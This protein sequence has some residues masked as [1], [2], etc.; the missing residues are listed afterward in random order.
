ME[1]ARVKVDGEEVVYVTNPLNADSD[2]DNLIDA[3]EIAG[4]AISIGGAE[5]VVITNPN[6]PDTDGDGLTDYDEVTGVAYGNRT[7]K[8][9][10][11]SLDSDGDGIGDAEE[12]KGG[13]NPA[14]SDTDGDSI[15]DGD[16]LEL[17][18]DPAN[19]DTDGD[20]KTDGEETGGFERSLLGI[21][22]T[23]STD[24][25]N[26]DTDGD[27]WTD[28]EDWVP[29]DWFP[30]WLLR[31]APLVM[32]GLGFGLYRAIQ[33]SRQARYRRE[34]EPYRELALQMADVTRGYLSIGDFQRILNQWH[35]TQQISVAQ[36]NAYLHAYGFQPLRQRRSVFAADRLYFHPE[37]RRSFTFEGLPGHVELQEESWTDDRWSIYRWR[38]YL[39]I[40]RQTI[41]RAL[42]RLASMLP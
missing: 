35:E 39:D 8:I 30:T 18:T 40:I 42:R 41:E 1:G 16:E 10:P 4:F 21:S 6:L 15:G 31:S 17:G 29:L 36:A 22:Y 23:V 3:D 38:E 11:T 37:V 32:V 12:A 25:T 13:S 2:G 5:I 26:V 33:A 24:P 19:A 28:D 34:G 9:D 7:W 20:G 27:G 14:L